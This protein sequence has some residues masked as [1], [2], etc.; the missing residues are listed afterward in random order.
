MGS[1]PGSGKNAS[2]TI[3][4]VAKALNVSTATVSRAIS[5]K[6]RIGEETV[7]RV[8]EY[9]QEHNYV[10]NAMAQG[11]ADQKTYNIGVIVPEMDAIDSHAFFRSCVAGVSRE[12]SDTLYDILTIIDDDGSR[13]KL[14][15]ALERGKLDGAIVSRAHVGGMTTSRL[16][17]A[18][19]PFV[20]VGSSP[21][22]SIC[23]VDHD[24]KTACAELT[25]ALLT[26][27]RELALLGD[28]LR[29]YVTQDRRQGFLTAHQEMGIPVREDRLYFE[30][31]SPERVEA[32]LDAALS[33]G[34]NCLVCIDDR[35][36][37]V[38]LALLHH[39]ELRIPQD[40][41]V[42]SFYDS[43]MLERYT[44]AITALHFDAQKLGSVACRMLLDQLEGRE[45][46]AAE[47]VGYEVALRDS[48]QTGR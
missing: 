20:L 27:G 9:I 25:R 44:P 2:L 43:F 23:Q 31:N 3:K 37:G 47:I 22:K 29:L 42:A 26:G 28:D 19:V 13:G 5:G 24:H 45:V 46:G 39:R 16:R 38:V 18:G 34:A 14:A 8:Q 36:C 40:V 11:L 41:Q 4:D 32:A 48:T 1:Q 6:G 10:P 7:R 12:L 33:S 17:Q 21:D 15:R 35:I 30:L